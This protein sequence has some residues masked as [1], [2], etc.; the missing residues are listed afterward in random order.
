[1][2]IDFKTYHLRRKLPDDRWQLEND[3]DGELMIMAEIELRELYQNKQMS[4]VVSSDD[5]KG[6]LAEVIQNKLAKNFSDYP[7]SLR[8]V[9]EY[10]LKCIRVFK[11]CDEDDR[12]GKLALITEEF[13]VKKR[14]SINAIR[15]WNRHFEKSSENIC[16]LIPQYSRRGNKKPRYSPEVVEIAMRE[17]RGL[18][19][20]TQRYSKA[21][22]LSSIRDVI[23]QENRKRLANDKLVKPGIK[24]LRGLID[25]MDAYDLMCA[26]EGKA[27]ANRHFRSALQ[28]GEIVS[29][30]LERV[31]IDHTILDLIVVHP[32]TYLPLGRPTITIALDRCTRCIMGYYVSFE[33]PSYVQVMKCL[34]HAIQPKDYIRSKYP[35]I[36]NNWPCWGIPQLIVVDNGRE[37]H[38][39]DLEAAALSLLI[40]VRYC[41]VAQPW[42]KGA[43]ERCFRT[44][45][46]SLIHNIP[47]STFSNI[48]ERGDYDSKKKAVL[49]LD[50]LNEVLHTWICD[51]YH[52]TVNRSTLHTPSSRWR[53]LIS[54]VQQKLPPSAET[55][56][57]SLDS[58]ETR[59]V[60]HYGVALNELTYNSSELQALRRRKGNLRVQIRWDRSDLGEIHILDDSVNR[61]IK[62]P[63]TWYIYAKGV[64]LWLHKAIRREAERCEG[65]ES[66]AKLD[67]AK[68]RLRELCRQALTHKKLSTR[69]VAARAEKGLEFNT[70]GSKFTPPDSSSIDTL[71]VQAPAKI[72]ACNFSIDDEDGDIPVFGV[73]DRSTP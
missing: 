71:P 34:S 18:Y 73:I 19:L 31:E 12:R 1:M 45:N 22:T 57:I 29:G 63:C 40:D 41:P 54:P 10:R 28:S 50:V 2:E 52:Q 21:E 36:Q 68:A 32:D 13:G 20:T 59:T 58:I 3:L 5:D 11:T 37:F 55:L 27:V 4:F 14:P 6:I 56:D 26:R 25:G 7:E 70:S 72:A 51:I 33:P 38:S 67:A 48:R 69:H 65:K 53:D 60:F 24:F 61:Y 8:K 43:V 44:I 47:G 62:V 39:K 23:E 15:R 49:T 66:E 35:Q 64:S 30:P 16:S 9:A 17:L 42:W 46:K